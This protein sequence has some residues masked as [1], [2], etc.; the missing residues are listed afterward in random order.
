M[1]RNVIL[2]AV[3]MA[4]CMGFQKIY[5]EEV[6]PKKATKPKIHNLVLFRPEDPIVRG[7][8]LVVTTLDGPAW[9]EPDSNTNTPLNGITATG[10]YNSNGQQEAGNGQTDGAATQA[11][12]YILP[13]QLISQQIV[14][15]VYPNPVHDWA[16]L[17]LPVNAQ[18]QVNI[19]NSAG[20]CIWSQQTQIAG[21]TTSFNLEDVPN[22]IYLLQTNYANTT[23]V[24]KIEVV[25]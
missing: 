18:V 17:D 9:E 25:K 3:F 12:F 7:Q 19:Y 8:G 21:P 2:F 6:D 22:G 10:Y 5:A 15:A 11:A 13:A 20:Q 1:L 4:S 24:Q 16:Y 23:H 14:L